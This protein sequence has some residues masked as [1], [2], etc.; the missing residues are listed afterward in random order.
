MRCGVN[1]V[2]LKEKELP[3][4]LT[5]FQAVEAAYP[6]DIEACVR[7]LSQGLSVLAE[8]DKEAV[9]Y[10]Y[11][12]IRDR[13]KGK[14]K[15]VYID[16][17]PPAG[18]PP[19]GTVATYVIGALTEVVRGAADGIVV[20]L[21]HLD[22]LVTSQGGLTSESREMISLLYENP[23]LVVLG[24]RDP[25]FS[26][27]KVIERLFPRQA[28][29]VGIRRDRLQHLVTQR[30]AR[31]FGK[32]FNPYSLYKYVSGLNAVRLRRLLGAL[33]GED[34]PTNA[35]PA[36][37]QLREATLS[38]G[39]AI[40]VVDLHTDIGGYGKV[41]NQLQQEIIDLLGKKD[42]LTDHAAITRIEGL[43]PRGMIFWGPAGTGKTLLA[44]AM[45]TSLGAAIQI[46]NGPE[47]KSKWYGES[48]G[49]LRAVFRQARQSAPSLIV[50]D[51][52]DSIAAARGAHADSSG[53]DHSIVNQLLTE[54]DGFR[55]EELVFVVGTTNFVESL[56]PALLRPGRFEFHIEIPYPDTK[57]RRE[58][59]EIYNRK[60]E[61]EMGPEELG[62]ATNRTGEAYL[63]T[64]TPYAGDHIN[65]LCRQLARTRIREDRAGAT[66]R[67]DIDNAVE[68]SVQ[69]PEFTKEE[70]VTVAT[71]ESGHALVAM[72]C[73][74]A[75]PIER[76]SIRGDIS[77]SMGFVKFGDPKNRFVLKESNLLDR[78]C[79]LLGGREAETL[80]CDEQ[81]IG[82]AH[83]LHVA[84]AM[85]R[86]MVTELGFG[87]QE[88]SACDQLTSETSRAKIEK[89][90]EALLWA[91]RARAKGILIEHREALISLRDLLI[92]KKTLNSGEFAL[93]GKK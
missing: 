81:S 63:A 93:K 76:I 12:S 15:C 28:A 10:I 4:E 23:S 45:A 42:S 25:S 51:E 84:T 74:S 30:E 50:F 29:F 79:C 83:D 59:I 3:V 31:K 11:K 44:K 39:M 2:L 27:P 91:Q 54:M 90:M 82:A 66:T 92:E 52:L 49:N 26:V 67:A 41:K 7:H 32:A 6:E 24:F 33:T 37:D 9:P 43:L 38:R 46:V 87:Q 88:S 77:G 18:A 69:R 86:G 35:Q 58:I 73:P 36:F 5:A 62:H 47:L 48:E 56:D 55:K 14:L 8:A 57:D 22:L 61:L 19:G 70:E 17:R 78:I 13:L 16:G 68:A 53:A 34:Y 40:P 89:D 85:A 65:A 60:F 1:G 75:P 72:H 21:P 64:G 71:H 80:L 20:V